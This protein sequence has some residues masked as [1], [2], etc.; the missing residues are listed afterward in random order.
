MVRLHCQIDL[1]IPSICKN[2]N[3]YLFLFSFLLKEILL[4]C[5][6][7]ILMFWLAIV[8]LIWTQ[9]TILSTFKDN[10]YLWL[11]KNHM[12]HLMLRR[13][14]IIGH[15]DI[16]IK[17]TGGFHLQVKIITI[18]EMMLTNCKRGIRCGILD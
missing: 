8:Y 15:V 9:M 7:H 6:E 1:I 18:V 13:N 10:L 4:S 3:M 11:N 12:M 14:T 17:N 5:K 2:F 16:L